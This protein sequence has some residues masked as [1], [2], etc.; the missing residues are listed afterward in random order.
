MKIFKRIVQN[1]HIKLLSLVLAGILWIYVNSIQE[2]ERFLSV[3]IE[4]KN[5][6]ENF[7]VSNEL[8]EFVQLVLRG[9]EEYLSLIMYDSQHDL[10]GIVQLQSEPI[11]TTR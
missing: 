5:I 7:L 2:S 11:P 4:V 9:R 1:W 10:P 8:P 3:P 6:S